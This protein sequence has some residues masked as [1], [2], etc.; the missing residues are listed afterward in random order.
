VVWG[1]GFC[2]RAFLSEHGYD[3]DSEGDRNNEGEK[4]LFH[5]LASFV[6]VDASVT[7]ARIR[8]EVA[9]SA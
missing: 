7:K 2:A 6:R 8:N 9:K 3:S 1:L 4:M 5:I